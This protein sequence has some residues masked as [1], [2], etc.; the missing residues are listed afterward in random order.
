MNDLGVAGPT[1]PI[2][3]KR[4]PQRDRFGDPIPGTGGE[5]DVQGCLFAPGQSTE[6][7]IGEGSNQLRTDA[8]VYAPLDSD[9]SNIDVITVRGLDY[10]V[11]GFIQAWA[12]VGVVVP[13]KRRTG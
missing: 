6:A 13:L 5:W 11:A 8:T 12:T 3:V 2:T 4:T 10:E 1:E 9:I 7:G